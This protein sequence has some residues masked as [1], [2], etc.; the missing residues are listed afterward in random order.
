ML[1]NLSVDWM[2]AI[3]RILNRMVVGDRSVAVIPCTLAFELAGASQGIEANTILS[4]PVEDWEAI[5]RATSYPRNLAQLL[6]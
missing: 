2:E 3:M 6:R 1:E 5:A 4:R